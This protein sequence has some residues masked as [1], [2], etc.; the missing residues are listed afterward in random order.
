MRLSEA[1]RGKLYDAVSIPII[2]MRLRLDKGEH[3]TDADL[4]RLQHNIW[5]RLLEV[6]ANKEV[7]R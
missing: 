1:Q 3:P 7:P 5:N 2:D 6:L 4:H